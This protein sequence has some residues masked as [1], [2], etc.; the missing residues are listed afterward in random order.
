MTNYF[1]R[2]LKL[3]YKKQIASLPAV[4]RNDIN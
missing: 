1:N 3:F 2:N 4:V